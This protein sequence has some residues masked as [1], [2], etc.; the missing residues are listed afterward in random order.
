MQVVVP[1][2]PLDQKR[3]CL[4]VADLL[5]LDPPFATAGIGSDG[6]PGHRCNLSFGR[7]A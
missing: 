3:T 6:C 5:D 2:V 1:D 7:K 4:M